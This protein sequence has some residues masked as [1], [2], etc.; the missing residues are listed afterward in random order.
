MNEAEK[1]V[2]KKRMNLRHSKVTEINFKYHCNDYMYVEKNNFLEHNIEDAMNK[3]GQCYDED[4]LK[5]FK[6]IKETR[7]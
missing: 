3:M 7:R 2:Q 5:H 6:F 4:E 1:L